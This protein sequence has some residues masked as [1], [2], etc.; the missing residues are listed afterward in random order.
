MKASL[1]SGK[2]EELFHLSYAALIS[3]YEAKFE[4][5]EECYESIRRVLHV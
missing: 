4:K 1:E 5:C 2:K 3:T